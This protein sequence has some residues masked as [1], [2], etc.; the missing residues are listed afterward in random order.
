M[1]QNVI[2][3]KP[4]RQVD[5]RGFAEAMRMIIFLVG[6]ALPF[7]LFVHLSSLQIEGEYRFSRLVKERNVLQ[8]R[9]EELL[10]LRATLL[11]PSKV[12]QVARTR[13]KMVN[14]SPSEPRIHPQKNGAL[15]NGVIG[16]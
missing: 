2:Q 4:I 9:H 12:E 13:L 7:I 1:M 11:S 16:P 14:E 6:L 8:H 10:L 15:E 5:R 3:N